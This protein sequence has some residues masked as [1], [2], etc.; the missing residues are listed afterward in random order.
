MNTYSNTFFTP[1]NSPQHAEYLNIRTEGLEVLLFTYVPG[2]LSFYVVK[3]TPRIH[4]ESLVVSSF[5]FLPVRV[6]VSE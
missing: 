1:D 6:I 5:L 4:P 3:R 2:V